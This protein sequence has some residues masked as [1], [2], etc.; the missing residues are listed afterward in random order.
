[1]LHF[2]SSHSIVIRGSHVARAPLQHTLPAFLNLN[3]TP[4]SN[5]GPTEDIDTA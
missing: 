1:M 5:V 2:V 4:S 3:D